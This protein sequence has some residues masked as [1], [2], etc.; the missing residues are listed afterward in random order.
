[1]RLTAA[2]DASPR[3][4]KPRNDHAA[5]ASCP[6]ATPR[7]RSPARVLGGPA[8]SAR[9]YPETEDRT[10]A[11]ESESALTTIAL[12][13]LA[14]RRCGARPHPHTSPG[15][16]RGPF[17]FQASEPPRRRCVASRLPQGLTL[18]SRETSPVALLA[19]DAFSCH[20]GTRS[21]VCLAHDLA[22]VL[23]PLGRLDRSPNRMVM[24]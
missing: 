12:S 19:A 7:I 15:S 18:V 8:R 11:L 16:C 22:G 10:S 2:P 3:L 21:P 13:R 6:T 20:V 17:R 23:T 24:I 4:H 14:N 5:V 9:G 1:M